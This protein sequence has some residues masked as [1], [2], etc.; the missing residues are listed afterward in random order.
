[1]LIDL[2]LSIILSPKIIKLYDFNES[3]KKLSCYNLC[4]KKFYFSWFIIK[5]VRKIFL[6]STTTT[7]ILKYTQYILKYEIWKIPEVSY[8][9]NNFN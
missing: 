3:R 7:T 1:M 8:Y 9:T 2:L 6:G 4:N 5:I